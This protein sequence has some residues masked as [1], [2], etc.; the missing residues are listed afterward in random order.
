[1]LLKVF[2]PNHDVVYVKVIR[3]GRFSSLPPAN[4]LNK[5][6]R[7]FQ[8]P[9]E[10]DVANIRDINTKVKD[11]GTD[12]D[13]PTPAVELAHDPIPLPAGQLSV[14]EGCSVLFEFTH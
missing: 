11:W 12:K 2:H 7:A 8:S 6:D 4:T 3:S 1:M 10:H 13:I 5:S 14:E 9:S